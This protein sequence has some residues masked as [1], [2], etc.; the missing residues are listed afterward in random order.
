MPSSTESRPRAIPSRA[1]NLT[2]ALFDKVKY[3]C[4]KQGIPLDTY[5]GDFI[6]AVM[7]EWL[8]ANDAALTKSGVKRFRR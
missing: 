4:Q 3:E 7:L 5:D 6:M 1:H 8:E 2:R